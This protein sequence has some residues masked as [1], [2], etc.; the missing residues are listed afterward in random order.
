[1][2]IGARWYQ[3]QK[4]G[5]YLHLIN[6][7]LEKDRTQHVVYVSGLGPIWIRPYGEF[8]DGR[9]KEYN[10]RDSRAHQPS[11]GF[12][13]SDDRPSL[14]PFGFARSVQTGGT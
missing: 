7:L 3:H 2:I 6:G 14:P 8:H 11:P 5:I 1:M 13:D 4:G 9:F 10:P 12:V